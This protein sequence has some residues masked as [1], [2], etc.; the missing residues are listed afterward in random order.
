MKILV[1]DDDLPSVKMISYLLKEEGH[2]VSSAGDGQQALQKVQADAPDL[3]IMDVM[4]PLMDG[5]EATRRIRQIMNVPIIILSAKG[6]TSDKVA[7]LQLGA[8]DYLAK[9]FEPAELLARVRA[10]LRRSESVLTE[11]LETRVSASGL[12]LEPVEH[13]VVLPGGAVVAL[14]TI[15]FKL[16]H[17][18]MRNAGRVV[19]PSYLLSAAWGYDYEG[20]SNQVAV[21]VRRLRS[22]IEKDPNNP[23]YIVTVRGVGYRFVKE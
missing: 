17:C 3:I 15:E 18:L 23:R 22:K 2:T 16:L 10:V 1:V 12:H 14:T 9:P 13:T 21:Y 20:E 8:D 11:D 5:F 6:E 19:T 4:M 7:G